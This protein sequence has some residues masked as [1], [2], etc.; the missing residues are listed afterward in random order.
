[1]STAQFRGGGISLDDIRR[2]LE[3]DDVTPTQRSHA[4]DDLRRYLVDNPED[5]EALTL[6]RSHEAE[7]GREPATT[8]AGPL[9]GQGLHGIAEAERDVR[10][11]S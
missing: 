11:Q 9:H 3:S 8:P 6:W 10:R 5:E 2:D 7:F 1:M 4:F